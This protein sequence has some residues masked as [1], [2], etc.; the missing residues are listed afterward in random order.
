MVKTFLGL[1]NLQGALSSKFNNSCYAI[2]SLDQRKSFKNTTSGSSRPVQAYF[3]CAGLVKHLKISSWGCNKKFLPHLEGPFKNIFNFLFRPFW[4]SSRIAA[5]NTYGFIEFQ[6]NNCL[7][8][9][10]HL[11]LQPSMHSVLDKAFNLSV[12]CF[13]AFLAH[14]V[15]SKFYL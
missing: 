10:N 3:S 14:C 15:Y 13:V 8:H 2:S 6:C 1:L 9:F 7:A 5:A 4:S 12:I 11:V